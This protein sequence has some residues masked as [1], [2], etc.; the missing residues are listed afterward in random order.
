MKAYTYFGAGRT[1]FADKP[2]PVLL[3]DRDAIVRVTALSICTSDLHIKHGFV[4]RAVPGVTLGHEFVGT[5]ESAG[6]AV[7]NVAPGDRVAVNVETFC[8]E[9]FF[10]RRGSVNNCSSP[11]GGWSL[12]C[13]IDGAQTE[14]VRVP[15]ADTGLTEIPDGVTDRQA[16]LTG[17]VLATGYWA[18]DIAD[19]SEGDTVLVI[20][21]G[22]VGI[23]CAECAR[24]RGAGRVFLCEADEGRR[25]FASRSFPALGVIAP[26]EAAEYVRAASA[27]GGADAVIEAA[28]TDSSFALAYECARPASSVV[29]AAMYEKPPTFPLPDIYGKNL[30]FKTGG[31]DGVY[32]A[33]ELRLIADGKLD[34]SALVTHEFPFARLEEAYELFGKRADGVMKTMITLG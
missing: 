21:G 11:L 18:A 12:G 33:E 31:V 23:C 10:C 4:P 25:R 14:Y 3:S 17:D 5:V 9:C 15:F 24:L 6:S 26:E 20:G 22:P 34:V 7:G 8:G 13:R 27:H 19:I 30:T 28:G 16:L 29:V 2:K 1:A 32:C